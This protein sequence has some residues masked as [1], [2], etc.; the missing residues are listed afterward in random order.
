[1]GIGAITPFL[2]VEFATVQA[3]AGTK[4]GATLED[5][6]KHIASPLL[7][8]S[9]EEREG[10]G[11]DVRPRRRRPPVEHWNLPDVGH[12]AA[13]RQAA[14]AV[15]A[16]RHGVL[17][18]RADA[19]KHRAIG[20]AAPRA[21]RPR[22]RGDEQVVVVEPARTLQLKPASASARLTAR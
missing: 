18:R 2:A 6:M 10:V 9:A 7:L 11:R 14:P 17:R 16:A 20:R 15:R 12:T 21:P 13:I 1:M 5:L 22:A 8:V 3:T 4:P 19:V